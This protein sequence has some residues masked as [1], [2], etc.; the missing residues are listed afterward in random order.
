MKRMLAMLAAA[1]VVVLFWGSAVIPAQAAPLEPAAVA[2]GAKWFV[3][4]DFDDARVSKVG[5]YIRAKALKDEHVKKELAKLHDELGF[6]P[7]KDLHGATLYGTDFT[8][9]TGV[10]IVY[11]MADKDKLM[12]H[13]KSKHDFIALKTADGDHDLYTWTEHM[14]SKNKGHE[15]KHTVWASFP[16]HGVGVFA[17]SA[18]NLKAALD[19]IGGKGGLTSGSP[20]LIDAPPGTVFSGAVVG[21]TGAHLPA[22]MPLAKQIDSVSFAAGESDGEDFDHIKVTMTGADVTKQV[23][24]I[25]E[26]FQAMGALHLASHPEALKMINGLKV[27]ATG[28]VLSIDW[29]A[30]SDDVIKF[31][32]KACEYI[33]QHHQDWR[34]GHGDGKPSEKS[35]RKQRS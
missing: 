33:R 12:A 18:T 23:K 1:V 4:I 31:G 21:L 8:P 9:H 19:V 13:L 3:H 15:H 32:E 20:L 6:D 10:L 35:P 5:E 24:T 14:G 7:Q 29:K 28:K 27:D 25:I 30:S 17:D 26:G 34:H 2:A 11:A 22:R 16:K